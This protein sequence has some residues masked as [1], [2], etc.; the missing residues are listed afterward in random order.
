LFA[1]TTDAPRRK[2]AMISERAGSMPPMT[3]TTR[4]TSSR[5]TKPAA[6]VVNKL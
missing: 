2:A 3:S 6:S 5:A 4:S 1:V